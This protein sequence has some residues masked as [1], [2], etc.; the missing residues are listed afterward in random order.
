[1]TNLSPRTTNTSS[2]FKTSANSDTRQVLATKITDVEQLEQQKLLSEFENLGILKTQLD[3]LLEVHKKIALIEA[4]TKLGARGHFEE[5]SQILLYEQVTR[6]KLIESCNR[7]NIDFAKDILPKI[8]T[9]RENSSEKIFNILQHTLETQRINRSFSEKLSEWGNLAFCSYTKLEEF[10]WTVLSVPSTKISSLLKELV[11]N[12]KNLSQALEVS[13]QAA[14]LQFEKTRKH[15]IKHHQQSYWGSDRQ[16][17]NSNNWQLAIKAFPLTISS[18]LVFCGFDL[19]DIVFKEELGKIVFSQ[20][21]SICK[22][23]NQ[24]D[25]AFQDQK[26]FIRW[27]SHGI[28][29]VEILGS[30]ALIASSGGLAG[31][32]LGHKAFL[33]SKYLGTSG[34]MS[35]L[36]AVAQE[37]MDRESED[38]YFRALENTLSNMGTSALF[39]PMGIGLS[40]LS[41]VRTAA[42]TNSALFNRV[43][44][45]NFTRASVEAI[46]DYGD[47]QDSL[48]NV[49]D[50][51][52]FD[53]NQHKGELL[54]LGL[55]GSAILLGNNQKIK[56]SDIKLPYI[57]TT[58][59]NANLKPTLPVID[60]TNTSDSPAYMRPEDRNLSA[61]YNRLL[62][63]LGMEICDNQGHVRPKEGSNPI[64]LNFNLIVIP[65]GETPANKIKILHGGAADG[66]PENFLNKNGHQQTKDGKTLLKNMLKENQFTDVVIAR[67]PI[68]RNLETQSTVIPRSEFPTFISQQASEI[69]F[70]EGTWDGKTIEEVEATLGKEEARWVSEWRNLNAFA[71][72]P[73]GE[74]MIQLLTRTKNLLELWN[75]EFAGKTIV[76]FSN[77]TVSAGI[78]ILTRTDMAF[79]NEGFLDWRSHEAIPPRGKPTL[80]RITNKPLH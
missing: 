39:V 3:K 9:I 33:L 73:N 37:W 10:S 13:D 36:S 35:F 68:S 77:G 18:E 48:A 25:L 43:K 8:D 16:L 34:A 32:A 19:V 20:W 1:M 5:K 59:L 46:D 17:S 42:N 62:D 75:R 66:N 54:Q 51:K 41:N 12:Q 67:P 63:S 64:K 31:A 52:S 49:A 74:N 26:E 69:F 60:T 7:Y 70:G 38:N 80:F 14:Y 56:K 15:Y 72:S 47:L 27:W 76:F 79:T 61:Y 44:I 53:I 50:I 28:E 29:T 45:N 71:R 55:A 11:F 40:K 78:R 2:H 21:N 65:H 30:C 22:T 23:L 58:D 24:D 57:S 6:E 4:Q